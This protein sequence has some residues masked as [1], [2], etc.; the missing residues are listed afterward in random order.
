M[1]RTNRSASFLTMTCAVALCSGNLHAAGPNRPAAKAPATRPAETRPADAKA[2]PGEYE[3]TKTFNVPGEWRWEGATLDAAGKLLYVPRNG[4]TEVI[5]TESGKVAAEILNKGAARGVALV[6]EVGRGFIS[7]GRDN[8]VTVFDLKTDAVLGKVNVDGDPGA[9]LYDP[10]SKRILICCTEG[11]CLVPIAPDID[12]KDGKPGAA[13]ELGAKPVGLVSDGQGTVYV[14]LIETDGIGV[15]D[16]NAMSLLTKWEMANAAR[17]VGIS[18]DDRGSR[19]FVGYRTMRVGVLSVVDGHEM[20]GVQVGAG[21]QGGGM[22]ESTAFHG[23]KVFVTMADGRL[24]VIGQAKDGKYEVQQTIA[25]GEGTSAMAVDAQTGAI[26]VPTF[27]T[28]GGKRAL[29]LLVVGKK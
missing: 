5:E 25:T 22:I 18:M 4:R 13:I 10:S 28:E 21:P 27:V 29:K 7:N 3:I 2:R 16:S 12:L 15:I 8:S 19:L 14:D 23:G 9:I 11:R 6:P 1:N 17:P 24:L 26:Y 20:A